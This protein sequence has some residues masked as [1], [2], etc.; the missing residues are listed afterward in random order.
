MYLED[1]LVFEFCIDPWIYTLDNEK[2]FTIHSPSTSQCLYH[3]G[4]NLIEPLHMF[5]DLLP[6]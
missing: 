2:L 3:T 5:I 6:R 4:L 1:Y